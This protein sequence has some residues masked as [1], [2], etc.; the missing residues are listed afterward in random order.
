M[1]FNSYTFIFV[2][3]PITLLGFFLLTRWV[4]RRIVV[5]W[6]VACSVVF[7]G[8]SRP[9]NLLLLGIL[10]VANYGFGVYL[11]RHSGKRR[12]KAILVLGLTMNLSVLGYFKYA[13]LLLEG[14]DAL[15]G[16]RWT[17][18]AIVL[19]L[20]ISFFILQ[21]IAYLVDAYAGRVRGYNFIDYCLFVT[22]FPQLIAGPIVHHS[23]VLPQI[24]GKKDYRPNAEDLSVGLTQLVFGLF[25]KVVIA[26]GVAIYAT[27]IFEAA[28]T[29]VSPSFLDGW[30]AALAYTFQ[31]YFDFS[32]YSDMALG[33]GRMFGIILPLNF[34]SPYKAAN[35][36][37]YWRRWHM[38][39]TRF[40][41]DY[42][43]LPLSMK[44]AESESLRRRPLVVGSASA[45]VTMAVCG[46]WHGNTPL[47]AIWGLGHG[48][49]LAVHQIYRQQLLGCLPARQRK[50]LAA[51]RAYRAASTALTFLAVVVAFVIFRSVDFATAA[52]I[53]CAMLG[54]GGI[55]LH[56]IFDAGHAVGTLALLLFMVWF[57][58]NTQEML[59]TV[60]PALDYPGP[61][62][63]AKPA[64]RLMRWLQWRPNAV[65]AVAIAI[66]AVFTI[67]QMSRISEFIYWQF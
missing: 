14:F 56:S 43:Y 52:R 5:L 16:A 1:P 31:I 28:R 37:E 53:L 51:N 63:G 19:P 35:I 44:L 36:A 50:A 42:L 57:L 67:T 55:Q 26:D 30:I 59:A 38:T 60:S 65:W 48:V 47:Y 27:P 62:V 61:D 4:Q 25:K 2:F 3:L 66:V 7:Y 9:E 17:A 29:G 8:S 23:E 39:L 22:F 20:G 11:C 46:L 54:A 45:I 41:R 49:M 58:P 24:A 40:L 15:T 32:G 6:L 21:K 18:G 12:A 34:N 64:G 10:L 33:L 13:K